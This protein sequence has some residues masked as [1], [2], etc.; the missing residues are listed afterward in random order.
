MPVSVSSPAPKATPKS[1]VVAAA[2]PA[3][4]P[5]PSHAVAVPLPSQEAAIA[6]ISSPNPVPV[7]PQQYTSNAVAE[8]S[9]EAPRAILPPF[10]APTAAPLPVPQAQNLAQTPTSNLQQ[11]YGRGA[12]SGMV[13]EAPK[14]SYS[15]QLPHPQATPL[16]AQRERSDRMDTNVDELLARAQQRLRERQ[17]NTNHSQPA[18]RA[19]SPN[20]RMGTPLRTVASPGGAQR[21]GSV[22]R[23][24]ATPSAG[25][26]VAPPLLPPD[27]SKESRAQKETQRLSDEVAFLASEN[28]RLRNHP[29]S[30]VT[31]ASSVEITKLE[32]QLEVAKKQC[33]DV[34]V[35]A[36]RTRRVLEEQLRDVSE[37]RNALQEEIASC[38]KSVAQF[39]QMSRDKD[40][41]LL[42]E[43]AMNMRIKNDLAEAQQEVGRY[44]D[45][46]NRV[47][48]EWSSKVD[49][50]LAL[51]ED[52]KRQRNHLTELNDKLSRDKDS[53]VAERKKL[54][55]DLRQAVAERN[56]E[57]DQA[58]EEVNALKRDV[59]RYR[60]MLQ[61]KERVLGAQ[62]SE[63]RK[64]KEALHAKL[65]EVEGSISKGHK[66]LDV[67]L[68]AQQDEHR[69]VAQR[70]QDQLHSADADL[71]LARQEAEELR[72]LV[73][74]RAE[75]D[76][77]EQQ[78]AYDDH[79]FRLRKELDDTLVALRSAEGA[80]DLAVRDAERYREELKSASTI[81]GQWKSAKEKVEAQNHQLT[82]TITLLMSSDDGHS[83]QKEQLRGQLDAQDAEIRQL[84]AELEQTYEL[85]QRLRELMEENERLSREC[86]RLSDERDELVDENGKMATEVLKWRDEVKDM[87]LRNNKPGASRPATAAIGYGRR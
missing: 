32:V 77:F 65:L 56:R 12:S 67:Q 80:R 10:P 26:L 31:A 76:R 74:T 58:A 84:Q 49:R 22:G 68:R 62:L 41:Q 36:Q 83:D 44:R 5:V 2:A 15:A 34:E 46:L 79:V 81:V 3:P 21:Y 29:A 20:V 87:L 42:Q 1:S 7:A 54:F 61:E 30:F 69:H 28:N 59:E 85:E 55:D 39:E 78:Q 25:A 40:S 8:V 33:R 4:A 16:R 11:Q 48:I 51:L 43:Q 52:M 82:T 57:K 27:F 14:P 45:D 75:R 6:S 23:A 72:A 13:E 60:S 47:S 35:E 64:A 9:Y 73:G 24:P 70:L 71:R 50:N 86:D 37:H 38:L 19:Q 63:E 18:A 53:A 66:S 17:Y